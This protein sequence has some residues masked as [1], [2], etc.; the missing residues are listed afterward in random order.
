MN[1]KKHKLYFATF[2]TDMLSNF[3]DGS[4]KGCMSD[5]NSIAF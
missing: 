3:G 5:T 4:F 2:F 1:L